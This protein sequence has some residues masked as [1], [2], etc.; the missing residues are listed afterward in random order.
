ME[1]LKKILNPQTSEERQQA[2]LGNTLTPYDHANFEYDSEWMEFV[3]GLDLSPED[4]RLI[5]DIWVESKARFIELGTAGGDGTLESGTV[6][7][8]QEGVKNRLFSRLSQVLSPEQMT[9]FHDHEEHLAM[10]TLASSQAYQEELIDTGYSGLVLAAL[11][12]DLPTVQA[13]LVSGADPNRFTTDGESA[14]HKAATNNNPEMLQALI[15]A[16]A[17]VNLTMPGGRS[18]LMDAATFGGADAARVLVEA[19]ADANYLRSDNPFDSAL[20][21]AAVDGHTE[22]VRILLDAGADAN[23]VVGEFALE[24]AIGFGDREMEQMLIEAG[25]NADAPRV[26]QRRS[27]FDLGRRLGLVDD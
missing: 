20:F 25:A 26:E 11:E 14:L 23:G 12:N 2:R 24:S 18:A 10:D 17:D 1:K 4:T 21:S 19:G 27:F 5:R 8:A 6:A 22:I 3:G 7:E 13:Y 9:A 16:G 15:D